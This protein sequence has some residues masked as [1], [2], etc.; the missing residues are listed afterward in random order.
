MDQTVAGAALR[1]D[2]QIHRWDDKF[3]S[4]LLKGARR[5]IGDASRAANTEHKHRRKRRMSKQFGISGFILTH[6]AVSKALIH[7]EVLI[8]PERHSS[9]KH[10]NLI[11]TSTLQ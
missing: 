4:L 3:Y 5:Y 11:S 8:V 2:R 9:R 7:P 6:I 1:G 10:S